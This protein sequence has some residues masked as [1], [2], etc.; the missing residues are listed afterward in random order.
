MFRAKFI[1]NIVYD[2]EHLRAYGRSGNLTPVFARQG[3]LDGACAIYSLMMMLIFHKK[4]DWKD[5]TDS[6][7]ANGN[8]FVYRIQQQFLHR[9]RSLCLG[10]YVIR[11]L[12][13]TLNQCFGE[14]LSEAF[15]LSSG[16]PQTVNRQE[17][18]QKIKAQLDA[19]K[20][21]LIGFDRES[22]NGHALV[23]VGCS[24][25]ASNRL[26]LFC[27]DSARVLP[28]MQI[29]NNVIDLDYLSKDDYALT[30]INYLEDKNVLVSDILIINDYPPPEPKC[31]F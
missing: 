9:F 7:R 28:Y 2:G 4:L 12:S 29:W 17:L 1:K 22:E 8:W 19:R 16:T 31:P 5:L 21:V 14:N 6:E 18:H 27:L 3:D 15:T 25:E 26:R 24:K 13:D 30:D 10:G 23:A 11:N 20:P